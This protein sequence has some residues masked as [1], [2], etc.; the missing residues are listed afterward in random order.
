MLPLKREETRKHLDPKYVRIM[1]LLAIFSSQFVALLNNSSHPDVPI[2]YDEAMQ[3][4]MQ[5]RRRANQP[6]IPK[7]IDE[8]EQLLTDFP[9]HG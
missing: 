6:P 7:N 5:R 4:R 9:A 2:G 1:W 8:A 3:R